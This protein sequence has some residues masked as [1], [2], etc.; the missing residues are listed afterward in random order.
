[1]EFKLVTLLH[2]HTLTHVYTNVDPET[3]QAAL[4]VAVSLNHEE[5]VTQLLMLGASLSVQDMKGLTPVMTACSYGHLQS[6]ECLAMK[7]ID[8]T[9]KMS[10]L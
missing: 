9:S 2:I 1:M 10:M 3:G 5:T 4:H 6:L 7:G 8:A